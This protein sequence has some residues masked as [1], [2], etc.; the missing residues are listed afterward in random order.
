[1]PGCPTART[2]VTVFTA[3]YQAQTETAISISAASQFNAALTASTTTVKGS[4]VASGNIPVANAYATVYD[5]AGHLVG[6]ASVQ[7][8]GTF[9]ITSTAG[10]N[11]V[12]KIF[13][14]GYS[15]P[16]GVVFNA[17]AGQTVQLTAVTLAAVAVNPAAA[18]P[19]SSKPTSAGP[20]TA[21]TDGQAFLDQVFQASIW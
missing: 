15:V 16:A 21:A 10:T 3:G 4:V 11:L 14:Q 12:L 5:S 9:Q 7:P 17:P 8:N 18:S 1:M 19:G 13:A 20:A 6:E 2:S